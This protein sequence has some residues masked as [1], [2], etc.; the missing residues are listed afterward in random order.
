MI[1]IRNDLDLL[2]TQE[3][4]ISQRLSKSFFSGKPACQRFGF[5]PELTRGEQSFSKVWRAQQGVGQP[6]D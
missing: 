6:F 2:P 4:W 1:V 5:Q 3:P